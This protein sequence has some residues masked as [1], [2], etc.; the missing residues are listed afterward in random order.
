MVAQTPIALAAAGRKGPSA[1]GLPELKAA[2]P[3]TFRPGTVRY[4]KLGQGGRWAEQ[5]FREQI[6]PF[7]Y[8]PVSHASCVNAEWEKVQDQLAEMGRTRAGV[9]QG[10]REL[11]DFY[12]LSENTLWFTIADGHLWWT[13]ASGDVIENTVK[14]TEAPARYRH[15]RDGWSNQSLSG[16][17]LRIS[18]MSSA[19]TSTAN[20]RMTLCAV[21]HAD[22]LLGRIFEQA[23]P[24]RAAVAALIDQARELAVEMIRRLDW[25]DMELLID[26]IFSRGGWTRI[27]ALGG[28]QADV[29]LILTQPITGERAWVQV[30]TQSSQREFEDYLDRFEREGSCQHFFFVY[31][32][33][34]TPIASVDATNVHLWPARKV[35]DAALRAGLLDWLSDRTLVGPAS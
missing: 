23:D 9:A 30:K 6:I 12:E 4:I 1:V 21:R 31:H 24:M 8:R 35:A 7:G 29:D 27:T 13:F 11:K 32:T 16:R 33:A 34:V 17:P 19:V 14:D 20:Y 5:A 10:L 25:R 22:H 18:D 28:G 15:T 26:M 2:D 3:R